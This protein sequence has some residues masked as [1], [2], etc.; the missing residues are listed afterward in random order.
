MPF[1][2]DGSS[3][4]LVQ[5]RYSSCHHLFNIDAARSSPLDAAARVF[6]SSQVRIGGAE[7][8][9]L[10]PMALATSGSGNIRLD[11]LGI[12]GPDLG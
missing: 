8:A 3:D 5:F 10:Q 12:W 4:Q 2:L 6:A 11:S 1:C 7:P 9:A